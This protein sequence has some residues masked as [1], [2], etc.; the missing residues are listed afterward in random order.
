MLHANHTVREAG[1]RSALHQRCLKRQQK[2]LAAVSLLF[3]RQQRGEQHTQ[4]VVSRPY[5]DAL[6]FGCL[7]IV[8][9]GRFVGHGKEHIAQMCRAF[10]AKE[11][12]VLGSFGELHRVWHG[13]QML[14]LVQ[15]LVNI[16][17]P[18]LF[19]ADV[20]QKYVRIQA[21]PPFCS[22]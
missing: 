5:A 8:V 16:D 14:H 1:K 6:Y 19:H 4:I 11:C 20:V 7:G 17:E 10:L 9:N 22:N 21:W 13:Q 12:R 3:V 18:A 15:L 2:K